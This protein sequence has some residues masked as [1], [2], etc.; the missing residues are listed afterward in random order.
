MEKPLSLSLL[1][2]ANLRGDIALLPRLF[3]F[4]QRLKSNEGLG[5]LILDLGKACH[6]AVP[7]C[8][9]TGGRSML[10]AL[11]GMGYHAANIEGAL[12]ARD[13][14]RVDEQ[15]TMALVDRANDWRYRAPPREDT[16]IRLTLRPNSAPARLQ[17]C[18]EPA[19]RTRMEGNVL[20]LRDVCAGQVGTASV[21]LRPSPRLRDSAILDLPPDTPPN[22]GITSAIEFIES[23]ARLFHRKRSQSAS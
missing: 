2:S 22:P 3:T 8:R 13:R 1:Y 15:V 16:G 9:Q 4:I 12:D 10:I 7:H 5:S 20:F 18:L 23:E 11:D 6:G 17:I 14:R 21:D 19:G